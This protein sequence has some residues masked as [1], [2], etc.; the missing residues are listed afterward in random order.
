VYRE[1]Q[2]RKEDENS[3]ITAEKKEKIKEEYSFVV[4]EKGGFPSFEV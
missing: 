3:K 2:N 4:E 1:I